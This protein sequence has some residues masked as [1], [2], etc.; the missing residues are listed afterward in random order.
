MKNSKK[1]KSLLV[2]VAMFVIGIG[3][4]ACE[5][6]DPDPVIVLPTGMVNASP[7]NVA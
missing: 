3:A 7:A 5:E 1:V 4:T 2:A 6:G